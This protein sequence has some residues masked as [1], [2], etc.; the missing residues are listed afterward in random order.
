MTYVQL[1]SI[2]GFSV[3]KLP[4]E[5]LNYGQMDINEPMTDVIPKAYS[6]IRS[7]HM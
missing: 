2:E 1:Q 6:I 7:V 5:K 3:V 4:A